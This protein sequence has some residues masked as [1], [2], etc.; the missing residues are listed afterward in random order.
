MGKRVGLFLSSSGG[1][2]NS[3]ISNIFHAKFWQPESA[4]SIAQKEAP[5][6]VLT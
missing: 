5:E 3:L 1:N 4:T 6:S 2:W